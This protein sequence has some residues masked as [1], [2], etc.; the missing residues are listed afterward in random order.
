MSSTKVVP[1]VTIIPDTAVSRFWDRLDV[2][3]QGLDL[4][5]DVLSL[6]VW[7]DKYAWQGELSLLDTIGRVVEGVYVN[8]PNKDEKL[9]AYDAMR[10]GLWIPAGRIFAGAGTDKYVTLMN[11]YVSPKLDDSLDSQ[12]EFPDYHRPVGIMDGLKVAALTQRM[13]GGIGIDFS[14]LRPNK[15]RVYRTS[16]MSSGPLPY[17]D[18]W[19]SMCTTI[20][21]AGNR[22]GAMIATLKDTH[23]DL[24]DFIRA[25]RTK[26]RLTNFNVSILVSDALMEAV[27]EDADWVLYF[28]VEP[29][30]RE[31]SLEDY[32]FTDD[33]GIKQYVYSVWKARELWELVTRS[34][35]EYSE[36]GV[37]FIDRINARN[38]LQYIEEISCTNPCVTGDTLILT[39]QGHRPIIDLVDKKVKIWNGEQFSEVVPFSTG[40]N[41][42]LDVTFSNG[43]TVRCT[44]YHKWVLSDGQKVE[45]QHLCAGDKLV[46][47][48]MPIILGG[49]EYP[50]DAYSQGF[51]C[52]DD[53][54][55]SDVSNLYKHEQGIKDRLVGKIWDRNCEKQPGSRWQHGQMLPKDFVPVDG[56]VQYTISWL[57]GLLDA[58]G[59]VSKK[60]S[61]NVVEISA[62]DRYFLKKVGLLLNRLGVNYRQWE[63]VDAGIKFGSNGRTYQCE[64]TASLM[65]SWK[66]MYQLVALGLKCERVNLSSFQKAPNGIA[67]VG[68]RVISIVPA[69]HEE[70]YCFNEPLRNMG[71]FNGVIGHNCG[72]QPL[73][74]NSVCNL[75][76]VNLARMVKNPFTSAAYFDY[77]LLTDVVRTG[78][79]FLDNVIDVTQYPIRAQQEEQYAKRRIGLGFTG[80]ADAMAQLGFRYGQ[81]KSADFA[82][83]VM[84]TIAQETY[85]TSIE[86]AKE[87][88]SFPAFDTEQYID[89]RSESFVNVVMPDYIKGQIRQFGIRNGV[90]GTVAPVGTMSIVFGNPAGGVE[91]TFL[92]LTKRNVLQADGVTYKPYESW[93]YAAKVYRQMFGKTKY[94]KSF[95]PY[96]VTAQDLSVHEHI[97]IQSRVQS[98]VD[99]SISKTLNIPTEMPYEEFVKVYNIAY[100]AGCKGCTTYRPSD[101]RGS[102]LSAPSA[103][104]ETGQQVVGQQVVN[105]SVDQSASIASWTALKA[106]PD[107]LVGK[108]YKIKWPQRSAA[109]YLTI[110]STEDGQPFEVFITSK[111][112]TSAEWTTALSLMITAIFRKGGDCRFIAEELKQIQSVR[113]SAWMNKRHFPSL[114]AYLGHLLEQHLDSVTAAA[115]AAAAADR[116]I[117]GTNPALLLMDEYGSE[118]QAQGTSFCPKCQQPSMIHTEGCVKCTSCMYSECS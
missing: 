48:D 44:K 66:G 69:G 96:M 56:T 94:E 74:E 79:R 73:P 30:E 71:V 11:C 6:D 80:L 5:E 4:L 102:I 55:N 70:T 24:P 49:I 109:L 104:R 51:Y 12:E 9:R 16:T 110:N 54:K 2:V 75:G 62:K 68:H 20:R 64:N 89:D 21:S 59:C 13:G 50:T 95:P 101:I 22:R 52:G 87:R 78:T 28:H 86:L 98:W 38:N 114:P 40:V 26:G 33:E 100:A 25:K 77:D 39:D 93:G 92:H 43:H 115:A 61:G 10:S 60:H 47:A 57:A 37:L 67:R 29:I 53:T 85:M 46:Y 113:D 23:P 91:P 76:H 31:A 14:P 81:V 72:E 99:A 18:M 112:G 117:K 90:S 106:R 32:D 27:A 8:D 3:H 35:Y 97:E 118:E 15:A 36:P 82:E 105:Q 42:V 7:R 108:T 84:K 103:A 19:D 116:T 111:D 41:D 88:G 58:D 34:T 1:Q 45:A 107:V 63:R 65:I 17:M 83:R